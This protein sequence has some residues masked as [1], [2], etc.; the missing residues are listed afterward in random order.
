[1]HRFQ[2]TTT[3]IP[4]AALKLDVVK[5]SS[6]TTTFYKLCIATPAML[7]PPPL[8]NPDHLTMPTENRTPASPIDSL[9]TPM[10][11]SFNLTHLPNQT[12]APAR[13]SF[14]LSLP[15]TENTK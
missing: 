9:S 8:S 13:P 6:A 5:H 10:S 1:M 15:K 7:E 2:P 11:P 12:S 3:F 4:C 14:R